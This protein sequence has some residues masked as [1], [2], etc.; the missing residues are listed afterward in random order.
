MSL[1]SFVRDIT[2]PI[3]VK[4]ARQIQSRVAL[5]EWEYLPGGF[6]QAKLDDKIKGWNESSIVESN[7]ASLEAAQQKLRAKVPIGLTE[8]TASYDVS[9]LPPHN[10]AMTFGAVLGR[11]AA[12]KSE[13]SVLDWGGALGSYY[14]LARALR[15]DLSFDYSLK[16][17]PI[18]ETAARELSPECRFW[19]DDAVWERQFD[20]VFASC[21][22]H[23][24]ENWRATFDKLA[25]AARVGLFVTRLPVT[26]LGESY[27]FVQRPYSYGYQ[28][29]YASWCL[30]RDEVL[31][32]GES[33]GLTLDR[34]FLVGENP[35]I[36][37]APSPCEYRGFLWMRNKI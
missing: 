13:L 30:N 6:A 37:G 1:R 33:C 34:E 24:E 15:P 5:R 36:Y 27:V 25:R 12:G 29:E 10:V 32:A 19:S 14:S 31:A 22:L 4:A 8:A 3:F 9:A 21:S 23:Y 2:P 20:L 17:M 28:T 26:L 18:F 7:T 11:V 16:E 35:P